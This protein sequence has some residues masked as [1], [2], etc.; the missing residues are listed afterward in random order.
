MES[1]WG[2]SKGNNREKK[3]KPDPHS[4]PHPH[5][6]WGFCVRDVLNQELFSRGTTCPHIEIQIMMKYDL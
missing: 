5:S 3:V 1:I 4:P 6:E 2:K